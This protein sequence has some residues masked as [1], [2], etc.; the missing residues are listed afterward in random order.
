MWNCVAIATVR[1][2]LTFQRQTTVA[3]GVDRGRLCG[4]ANLGGRWWVFRWLRTGE[5]VYSSVKFVGRRVIQHSW[6][7]GGDV[8]GLYSLRRRRGGECPFRNSVC[9]QTILT[10]HDTF[11]C[12]AVWTPHLLDDI[13]SSNNKSPHSRLCGSWNWSL[14][15]LLR[16]KRNVFYLKTR[17]VP[18]S[19]HTISRLYKPVS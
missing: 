19:K 12:S 7:S 15:D 6:C 18:R 16:T 8:S 1:D 3:D 13:S 2:M 10:N 4:A 5:R 17:S 9:P 11:S 14:I